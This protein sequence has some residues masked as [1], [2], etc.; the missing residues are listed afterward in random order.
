MSQATVHTLR[1]KSP[2]F[3]NYT[4]I[5][6]DNLTRNC[7]IID[8]SWEI[9]KI[10]QILIREGIF[11]NSI[12]LTHSHFDHTNLVK[13]LVSE[14]NI[15]VYMSRIEADYYKYNC[16]NLKVIEDKQTIEFSNNFIVTCYLSP[17]H[18]KGSMIYA[19]GN[20]IFTGDT[21][22]T[23]GC[24]ICNSRGGSSEDMFNTVQFVRGFPKETIVWP[25][26]AFNKEPGKSL[27]Q[28]FRDNIYFSIER[29]ED[30]I[31]FSDRKER[32][33]IFKFI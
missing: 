33:N 8:P 23:E 13:Q 1:M 24:G 2:G 10:Y 31:R 22:F 25:G 5:V 12:F 9:D 4:Y 26:H 11:L 6:V 28:V 17:G 27:D 29:K 21:I 3:I 16:K 7:I 20:N 32:G 30:F 18:T 15:K 14:F 19:V